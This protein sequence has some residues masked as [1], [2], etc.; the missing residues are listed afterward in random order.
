V[1]LDG[2]WALL[3]EETRRHDDVDLVVEREALP[4]VLEI[5]GPL[6]FPVA[7]DHSPVRVVRR[8]DRGGQVDLHPVTFAEDG[9]GGLAGALPDGSDCPDP[10]RGFGEGRILGR[11]F[12]ASLPSYSGSTTAATNPGTRIVPT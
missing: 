4:Q 3:G 10:A 7:E 11:V 8:S 5:L 6:G 12:P 9:T 2:G 1:W